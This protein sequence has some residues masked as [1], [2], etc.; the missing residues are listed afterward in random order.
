MQGPRLGGGAAEARVSDGGKQRVHP[1]GDR[2][3]GEDPGC[4]T[5]SPENGAEC[6]RAE[7]A[8]AWVS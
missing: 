5:T 4:K 3:A 8:Q 2:A 1:T 7:E 6:S